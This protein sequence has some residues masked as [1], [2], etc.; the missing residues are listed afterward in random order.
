MTKDELM[1]DTDSPPTFAKHLLHS[2]LWSLPVTFT[3]ITGLLSVFA[4]RDAAGGEA[5]DWLIGIGLM[6]AAV[7]GGYVSW[8][9]MPDMTMGE[10]NTRRGNNIRLL[11]GGI[12]VFGVTLSVILNMGIEGRPTVATLFGNGPLPGTTA[13]AIAA[14]WLIAMPLFIIF[15]RRNADEHA[16]QAGDFG[17]AVGAHFFTLVT[18]AWWIGARGGFLPEPD[19]MVIFVAVLI[20]TAI[21]NLWKR[22]A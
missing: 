11:I 12:V 20:V 18:P 21:A 4:L 5:M 8:R 3:L 6:I 19:V 17:L 10:P 13:A 16:L 2:V 15:G 9:T 22:F 1:D 7:I 14:L